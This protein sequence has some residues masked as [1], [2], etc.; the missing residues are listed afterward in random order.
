MI[1]EKEY[2]RIKRAADEARQARDRAAG[3]LEGVMERLRE[4]FGCD[5]IQAAEKKL[6]TLTKE[7]KA[8]EAAYREAVEAFEEKWG[9]DAEGS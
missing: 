2:K 8:A 7:A 9:D 1:D 5:T 6:K 4:E 3:H